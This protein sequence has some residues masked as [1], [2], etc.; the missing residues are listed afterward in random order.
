MP[1]P[2]TLR[3][4]IGLDGSAVLVGKIHRFD[5]WSQAGWNEMFDPASETRAGRASDGTRSAV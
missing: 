2:Q 1:L 5:L 4:R 3:K